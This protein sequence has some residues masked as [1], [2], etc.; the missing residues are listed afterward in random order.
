VKYTPSVL[1]GAIR[2]IINITD[3]LVVAIS[4]AR[5]ELG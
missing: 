3:E 2:D 1:L 5:V 4:S